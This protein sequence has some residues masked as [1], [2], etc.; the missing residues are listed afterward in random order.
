MAGQQHRRQHGIGAGDLAHHIAAP[1]LAKLARVHFQLEPDRLATCTGEH[2]FEVFGI[3][4]AQRA[5]RNCRHARREAGAAGVGIA[6]V[7]GADRLDDDAHRALA[8]CNARAHPARR[9][10]KAVV[11]TVLRRAHLV[12]DIRDLAL[13]AALGRGAQFLDGAE[14]HHLGLDP[15]C[16][17][18]RRIAERQ[19][20]QILREGRGYAGTGDVAGHPGVHHERLIRDIGETFRLEPLDCPRPPARFRLGPGLTRSDFGG[21]P[22]D[23]VP[24]VG[25]AFQRG[26]GDFLKRRLLRGGGSGQ[27]GERERGKRGRETVHGQRCYRRA[28]HKSSRLPLPVPFPI[29][30]AQ[31]SR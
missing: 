16:G 18:R 17:R 10:C 28:A 8:R 3:G 27:K 20:F 15:A 9:P 31:N 7:I 26:S 30:G 11:R 13:E 4:Q 6:V 24:C 19:H 21:D 5:R 12:A 29:C 1:R 23:E 2:A 25:V 14:E 22:F